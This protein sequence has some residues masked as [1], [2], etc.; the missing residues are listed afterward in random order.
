VRQCNIALLLYVKLWFVFMSDAHVRITDLLD[1]TDL[2][3]NCKI[4][5]NEWV[6]MSSLMHCH[7]L[8]PRMCLVLK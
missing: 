7:L 4:L 5:S 1:I 8:S 6:N 3:R 2:N